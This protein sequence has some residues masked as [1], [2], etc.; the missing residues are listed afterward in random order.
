MSSIEKSIS[1]FIEQQFPSFYKD[2]GP[3]FIAFVRSYYEW[4]E[5][6]TNAIGHARSLLD[7]NDIDTT[8]EQFIKNF[9]FQF[10]QSLP[11]NTVADKRL[12]IKHILDLYRSKGTP[13]AVE[14]LFRMVFNE[15]ID[16]YIPN[17]FIFKPSDNIWKVPRYLETKSNPNIN[18]LAGTQIQ[19]VGNTAFAVVESVSSRIVG[20]KT[21]NILEIS[22]IRGDFSR[23]DRIF[24]TNSTDITQD[25]AIEVIG[26]LTAIAVT[27]G[28]AD[29]SVGDI[30]DVT[31]SGIEGR[32]RVSAISD[33]FIGAL[34]FTI[35]DGG[36]GY[37]TNA[38]VTVQSTLNLN[39]TGLL[40][41]FNT[42]DQVVDSVNSANGTVL[43]ANSTTLRLIDFS[44]T[45]KFVVGNKVV[46]STGNATIT[47]VLGGVGTGGSFRVGSISNREVLTFNTTVIDSYLTTELDQSTN[48]LQLDVSSV[49]GTFNVGN[50]LTATANVVLLEGFTTTVSSVQTGESLSNASLGITSL[51]VYRSDGVLISCI[52]TESDL[53]NANLVAGISLV[54]N[55]TSSVFQLIT[56]PV[57][58]TISGE[59]ILESVNST[60]LIVGTVNGYFVPTTTVTSTNTAATATID[61]VIRLTDWDF[62]GSIAV[63]DNL[64]TPIGDVLP[65]TT[66][67]VGTIASLAQVSPGSGYIT[68]PNIIVVE[69][70]IADQLLF[71][72]NFTQKGNNAIIASTIAGGNGS[73]TAIEI[74]DTGYGYV[75]NENVTLL[76]ITNPSLVGGT[77]IVYQS[78]RGSGRWLNRKSFPSDVMFIQDG[79]F[80]QNYSYQVVAQRMLS[81]YE[82][83][84]RDL[85]H[86]SGVALFGTYRSIDYISDNENLVSQ[87]SIIQQ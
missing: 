69:P 59:A 72:S 19:N 86:P 5:Q 77:S 20:G 34:S 82:T 42:G 85:V 61:D 79:F 27:Q 8:P 75:D 64:D 68:T 11:E 60:A 45:P 4:M 78:G 51:F 70:V 58:E 54:S 6:S 9:K 22:S 56:T 65:L 15:D 3:N 55:T 76:S 38:I 23:G 71:D 13:R 43:S 62:D 53:D 25:Q 2:Q 17:E 31:G 63:L 50:E 28:G 7:Y 83:L 73:I 74:I 21:I 26:S 36:S 10:V 81:S 84:V 12:L 14:L 1:T 87:S 35:A 33:Q 80:Y 48:T 49:S 66:L 29:Y 18:R 40:G 44:D 24:Q 47:R 57:K 32:A 46:G 52:G 67:E 16:L 30:L 39:I 37:T 41:F